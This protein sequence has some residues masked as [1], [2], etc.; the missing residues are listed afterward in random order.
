MSTNQR[1]NPPKQVAP[2]KNAKLISDEKRS[3]TPQQ[4]P[5]PVPVKPSETRKEQ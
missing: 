1:A 4:T 2:P 5:K 3:P